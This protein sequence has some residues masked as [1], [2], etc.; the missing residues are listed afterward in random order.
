MI[1]EEVKKHGYDYAIINCPGFYLREVGH[2]YDFEGNKVQEEA[3]Y[4][5][6][7]KGSVEY[8][9]KQSEILLRYG[10]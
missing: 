10:S 9:C 8:P 3:F 5:V 7:V 4:I 2:R 6:Y 1:P